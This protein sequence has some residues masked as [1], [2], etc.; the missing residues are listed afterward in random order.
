MITHSAMLFYLCETPLH[1]GSGSS[2]TYVDLP[3]QR[4]KHTSYPMA[5]SSG[6]KGAFRE[7]SVHWAK[8]AQDD[9]E[10]KRRI[11]TTITVFGPEPKGDAPSDHGG[12]LSFTDAEILLFPVASFCGGFAWITCP[13]VILRLVRRLAMAGFDGPG[14]VDRLDP[15]DDEAMVSDS[16]CS[17]VPES[18]SSV[19]RLED[20]GF[21]PVREPQLDSLAAWLVRNA[22]AT[23]DDFAPM[24]GLGFRMA[25]LSDT[26]FGHFTQLSTEI[27]S[28]NRIGETGTV[29]SGALWTEEALPRES[30]LFSQ[31][32]DE[33]TNRHPGA[34]TEGN[35]SGDGIQH[36]KNIL[37]SRPL[38]QLGGNRTLGQGYA[39]VCLNDGPQPVQQ[40]RSEQP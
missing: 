22:Q 23:S 18:S 14:N 20:F 24:A 16:R 29:A 34:S 19:L 12:A 32:L 36:I 38:I 28:R 27:R 21:T 7:R 6:V 1:A 13:H 8:A 33:T 9:E 15:M 39:W 17:L 35:S 2:S 25:V 40:L 5:Q 30:I 37:G 10:R 26:T 3:I 4:E 31:V 11:R